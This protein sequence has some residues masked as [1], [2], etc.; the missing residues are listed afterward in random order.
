MAD[1]ITDREL[2]EKLE[3]FGIEYAAKAAVELEHRTHKLTVDEI[4]IMKAKEMY[5]HCEKHPTT[6]EPARVHASQILGVLNRVS[7][8]TL[9]EL[10]KKHRGDAVKPLNTCRRVLARMV[11]I[12]I[13]RK[14]LLRYV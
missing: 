12:L 8:E 13:D 6:N 10:F 14:G 5:D 2:D 4:L 11:E 9:I 1:K 7:D 3:E